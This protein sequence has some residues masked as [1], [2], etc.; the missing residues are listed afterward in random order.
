M[1]YATQQT[2]VAGQAVVILR[3]RPAN[4]FAG[5]ANKVRLRGLLSTSNTE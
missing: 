1:P 5:Y 2:P 4:E 3:D